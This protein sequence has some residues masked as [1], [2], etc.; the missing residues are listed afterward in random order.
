MYKC[1]VL[2][3][4]QIISIL[5]ESDAGDGARVAGEVGHVGA[6]LQVPDLDLGISR[7]S[8][9]NET[10]G[11]ELSTGESCRGQRGNITTWN[12]RS[13]PHTSKYTDIS[14]E[15]LT[16]ASTFISNLGEDSPSLDVR[17][18][19]VLQKIGDKCERG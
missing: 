9:K 2:T 1:T 18:G 12:K 14:T 19:P 13:P 16:T 4:S 10:I 5:R 17:K 15:A 3:C 6:L 11:V 8:A 7:P